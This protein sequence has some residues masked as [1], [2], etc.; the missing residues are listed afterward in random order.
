[1][2]SFQQRVDG[3]NGNTSA[4]HAEDRGSIPLRSTCVWC[5]RN[6][7]LVA[8]PEWEKSLIGRF[9]QVRVL[10]SGTLKACSSVVER[11][12]DKVEVGG[13]IPPMPTQ[14]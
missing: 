9:M 2:A 7:Q 10:S 5:G 13:S 4:L 3:D 6:A 8:N 1:M 11:N 14:P 12:P